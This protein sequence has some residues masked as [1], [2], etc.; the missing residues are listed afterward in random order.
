MQNTNFPGKLM[1]KHCTLELE[2][3]TQTK[4]LGARYSIG[5]IFIR[6]KIS[7]CNFNYVTIKTNA[8]VDQ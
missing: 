3:F 8:G 5:V 4:Q 2:G 1:I 6:E 7:W